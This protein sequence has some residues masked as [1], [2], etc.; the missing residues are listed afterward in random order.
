MSGFGVGPRGWA[1]GKDR[2]RVRIKTEIE[3]RVVRIR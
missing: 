3:A 1:K 2:A